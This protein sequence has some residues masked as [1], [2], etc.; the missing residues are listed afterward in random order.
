MAE[1]LTEQLVQLR[2]RA[3]NPS[4]GVVSSVIRDRDGTTIKVHMKYK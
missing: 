2:A 1:E 3:G 4:T